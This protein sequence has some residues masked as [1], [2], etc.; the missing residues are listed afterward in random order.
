MITAAPRFSP[1]HTAHQPDSRMDYFSI[2]IDQTMIED[3]PNDPFI[4]GFR[5]FSKEDWETT[6]RPYK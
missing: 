5:E 2:Q 6:K 3:E 4:P 1:S